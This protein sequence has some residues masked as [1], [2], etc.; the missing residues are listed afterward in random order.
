MCVCIHDRL[1]RKMGQLNPCNC[2]KIQTIKIL[3]QK[4]IL[5]KDDQL[6]DYNFMSIRCKIWFV[7]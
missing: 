7:F 6:D 2:Y 3:L 4:M 5:G 1:V